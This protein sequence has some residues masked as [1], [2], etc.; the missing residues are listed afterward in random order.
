M[1][2]NASQALHYGMLLMLA[3]LALS[4]IVGYFL[5]RYA[6]RRHLTHTRTMSVSRSL[7]GSHHRYHFTYL[8]EAGGALLI[9][10]FVGLVVHMTSPNSDF[11][12]MLKFS[13]R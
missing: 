3:C 12:E 6:S 11:E 5:H 9:G 1:F 2:V 8:H 4:Y 7:S 13:D 10:V